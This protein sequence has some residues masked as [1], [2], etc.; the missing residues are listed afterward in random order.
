MPKNPPRGEVRLDFDGD[1]LRLKADRTLVIPFE[2]V[3]KLTS[4]V[5][6]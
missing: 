4:I 3:R 1:G 5:E 2:T 6:D